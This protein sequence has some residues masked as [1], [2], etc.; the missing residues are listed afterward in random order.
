[1]NVFRKIHAVF[2][3]FGFNF[4]HSFN[5]DIYALIFLGCLLVVLLFVLP[6]VYF[7]ASRSMEHA[8]RK[9]DDDVLSDD[10]EEEDDKGMTS[11]STSTTYISI[12]YNE[13]TLENGQKKELPLSKAKSISMFSLRERE[14]DKI[15]VA[16]G[17][18]YIYEDK[19]LCINISSLYNVPHPSYGGPQI[20]RLTL[21]L[22]TK[23]TCVEKYKKKMKTQYLPLDMVT[24][25]QFNFHITVDLIPH[26]SLK[27]I[28]YGKRRHL[29]RM[30]K[31]VLG[32]LQMG[33]SDLELHRERFYSNKELEIDLKGSKK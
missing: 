11:S 32:Y 26:L 33:F 28:I 29:F 6:L 31:K 14:K 22:Q 19:H 9:L 10:G 1:M 4:I 24:P 21:R 5:L 18:K 3:E 2:R 12:N 15:T 13:A 27:L 17:Y 30:D 23:G 25:V 7:C 20:L 16:L 8:G